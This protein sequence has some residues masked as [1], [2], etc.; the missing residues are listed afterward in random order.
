MSSPLIPALEKYL[1]L[2]QS[3]FA[4]ERGVDAT[5]PGEPKRRQSLED[6]V[7]SAA[8]AAEQ[9]TEFSELLEATAAAFSQEGKEKNDSRGWQW[10]VKNF[11]RLSGVYL[12]AWDEK[13]VEPHVIANLY[14]Q[15]FEKNVALETYLAP[16]EFVRFSEEKMRFGQFE[17]RR[18]SQEELDTVLR[19]RIRQVFYPYAAVETADLTGYWF[20]VSRENIPVPPRRGKGLTL[21]ARLPREHSPLPHV[22]I[23]MKV[24]GDSDLIPVTGSEMK[25]IVFGAKRRWLSYP[26]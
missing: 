17:V 4:Q 24:I 13:P 15:E 19:N 21:T 6:R 12:D 7:R 23:P 9:Q 16:L 25:L 1:S 8:E 14:R 5:G 18:F 10:S 11:L 2:V 22:R 26:A 20:V 3:L